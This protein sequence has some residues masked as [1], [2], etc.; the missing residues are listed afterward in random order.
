VHENSKR[1]LRFPVQSGFTLSRIDMNA[2]ALSAL[3]Q[4]TEPPPISWL[5]DLAL[6]RPKLISLAAGFT[7]HESLPVEDV[8]ELIAGLLRSRPD[9]ETALQYGSTQGDAILRQR[10]TEYFRRLDGVAKSSAAW[11]ADRMIISNGSQQMLYLV[12]EA[13]CDAGD[14]VLVED[15]TYFVYLGILQSRGLAAR[16]VRMEHDGLD[17][18]HH[19]QVLESLRRRG[20]LRRVKLLYL[21]SYF[22]NPT[23]IT[24]SF[25]KKSGA[26]ALLRKYERAA[27]H[28]IYL[29]ED[30]AYRS[31]RFKGDDV[32]SGLAARGGSERVIYAGTYSKPFATGTRVGFGI[33]PKEVFTA[34][35]RIKGNHDFG[36][37]NLL[38]HL[39]VRALSSGRYDRHL[40]QLHRRYRRKAG[41][42]RAALREH[43]PA[44]VQWDDPE[45]GLY[46][47]ARLPRGM[48][49]TMDSK[50]FRTALAKNVFYV[51]GDLCYADD[52]RRR[53]PDNEMRISFGSASEEDIRAG[54]KRLGAVLQKSF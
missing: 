9:G 44:E 37:S 38:Q 8:R 50:L 34:A 45:G 18:A 26:L 23:G 31:L 43:F 19:D 35:L 39:M 4:R 52:P 12:T 32:K 46:F 24:T 7:D 27:G 33:L 10:T 30:A 1:R 5:M 29:L 3:A 16:G 47:W 49:S 21:V 48:K 51:P 2:S 28:P 53:K 15:P 14:I 17:L 54:I 42:M 11:S 22:Q 13:L 41:I 40:R 20:D 36:T 6:S 25:E